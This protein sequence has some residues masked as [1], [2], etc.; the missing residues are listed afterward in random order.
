MSFRECY[1]VNRCVEIKPLTYWSVRQMLFYHD[2][3]YD[4]DEDED[5][6]DDDDDDAFVESMKSW[7]CQNPERHAV[8]NVNAHTRRFHF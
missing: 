3:E 4:G 6:D 8:N 2:H 1:C 5:V 7:L